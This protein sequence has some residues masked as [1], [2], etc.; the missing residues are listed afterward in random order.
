[1]EEVDIDRGIFR[2]A[3]EAIVHDPFG[4]G[5]LALSVLLLSVGQEALAVG[6][7]A[8][9]VHHINGIAKLTSRMDSLIERAST[10]EEKMTR[11]DKIFKSSIYSFLF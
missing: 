2:P 9:G 11:L 3:I 6:S 5:I 7:L 4:A 8:G 1:M 10:S